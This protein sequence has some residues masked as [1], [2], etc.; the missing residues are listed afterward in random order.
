VFSTEPVE[1]PA[2]VLE[3]PSRMSLF[4]VL[5]AATLFL[6]ATSFVWFTQHHY[7]LVTGGMPVF[8]FWAT[9]V[10]S[11]EMTML[12]AIAATFLAMLWES[13]L[14][15]RGDRTPAPAVEPGA[16]YLRVRCAPE[17]M[18]ETGEILYQTGALR[19]EKLK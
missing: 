15:H 17:R 16:V 4:A 3:R 11:Y 6:L 13:G 10:I 5:G 8:S 12:G 2:G 19:V 7:P 9:G 14:L 1:L 18:P